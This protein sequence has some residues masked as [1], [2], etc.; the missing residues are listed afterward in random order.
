MNVKNAPTLL[1]SAFVCFLSPTLFAQTIVC[2][3]TNLDGFCMELLDTQAPQATANF[4]RYVDAKAYNDSLIHR[5]VRGSATYLA[6]GSFTAAL[7]AKPVTAS[8]AIPN[9]FSVANTRGTVAFETVAG[10][11]NSATSG[12][13]I[14]VGDNSG[15]FSSSSNSGAVFARILGNGMA[16]VDRLSK[17]SVHALN[18]AHLNQAPMLRLDS[19]I[20]DDDLVQVKRVYRY[21]GTMSDFN[22]FGINF[23]VSD[24]NIVGRSDVVCM[25]INLGDICVRLFLEDAPKTVENFLRYVNDGAYNNT[26]FHRLY[27]SEDK[28]LTVAQAGRYSYFPTANIVAQALY[29]PVV[30]EYKRSNVRGTLAMAKTA[31]SADSATSQWFINLGDNSSSLNT[32]N[33]GG[34]TVFAEVIGKGMEVVDKIAALSIYDARSF[35]NNADMAELPLV[36][37]DA[38]RSVDDFVTIKKA[39]S[40]GPLGKVVALATYGTASLTAGMQVPVRVGNKLYLLTIVNSE[41]GTNKYKVDTSKIIELIDNG[42]IAADFD[43]QFLTIPTVRWGDKIFTNVVLQLTNASTLELE[44]QNFEQ[45]Q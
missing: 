37:N 34:F 18:A 12:W 32:S 5:S 38:T 28:S 16:V 45:I 24:T 15:T 30:N 20:T 41:A 7:D 27:K 21:A 40:N 26:I 39:Y 42:R 31:A 36:Q 43:G 11:P 33:N 1:L 29:A 14:N 25:E 17:L 19:K 3:E 23:P 6:G 8:A 35:F 9:E 13:R 4:L 44:L 10:Q 2:V 22:T